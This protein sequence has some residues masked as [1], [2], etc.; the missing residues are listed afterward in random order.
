MKELMSVQYEGN[1]SYKIKKIELCL[2]EG[3]VSGDESFYRVE[4]VV[5]SS[6]HF[7]LQGIK[8]E[9]FSCDLDFI[10]EE[11]DDE[12]KLKRRLVGFVKRCLLFA[13]EK[14]FK[15]HDFVCWYS[16]S[17]SSMMSVVKER[18]LAERGM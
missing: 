7:F 10:L 9:S 12:S 17:L 16:K 13:D 1:F 6:S 3:N 2:S 5:S 8:F 11:L 4:I 15:N 14:M 18:T